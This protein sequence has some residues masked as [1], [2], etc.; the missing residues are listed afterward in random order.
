MTKFPYAML[1]NIEIG[2]SDGINKKGKIIT[3]VFFNSFLKQDL[4]K[5]SSTYLTLSFILRSLSFSL[6]TSFGIILSFLARIL[7]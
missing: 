1:S 7:N 6:I 3:S 2:T 5:L 4:L